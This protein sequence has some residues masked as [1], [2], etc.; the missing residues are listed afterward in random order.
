[1]DRPA[2]IVARKVKNMTRQSKHK[3]RITRLMLSVRVASKY[4]HEIEDIWRRAYRTI[5]EAMA[6]AYAKARKEQD[7]S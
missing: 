3:H 6:Q 5:S 4:H 2:R 7:I 1:M